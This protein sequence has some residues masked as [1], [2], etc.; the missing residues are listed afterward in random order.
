MTLRDDIFGNCAGETVDDDLCKNF[1]RNGKER[2]PSE[3][4]TAAPVPFV[5]VEVYYKVISEVLWDSLLFP[6]GVEQMCQVD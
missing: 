2:Y 3:I 6:D 1:S 4:V 5:L